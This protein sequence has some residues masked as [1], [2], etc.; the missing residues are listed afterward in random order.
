MRDMALQDVGLFE[1]I[2]KVTVM[3]RCILS[4]GAMRTLKVT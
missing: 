1:S 3:Y 4:L 2:V